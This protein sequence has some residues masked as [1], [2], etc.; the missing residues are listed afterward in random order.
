[1]VLDVPKTFEIPA[2]NESVGEFDT[3]DEDELRL[4]EAIEQYEASIVKTEIES[5]LANLD[6]LNVLNTLS[7]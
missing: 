6:S 2:D 1:M 4:L 7:V 3:N 5:R